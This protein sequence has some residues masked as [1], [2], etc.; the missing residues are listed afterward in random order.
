MKSTH[1]LLFC[2]VALLATSPLFA[3]NS[4][5][6]KLH[7]EKKANNLSDKDLDA[8]KDKVLKKV[9]LLTVYISNIA[10][11]KADDQLR[12]DNITQ[13]V[14]LFQDKNNTYVEVSSK[15]SNT[16]R[17]YSI[18]QYFRRLY[19]VDAG[20]V[21]ITFYEVAHLSDFRQ[22]PD[23]K[24]Y[25]TAHIYQLYEKYD[26]EGALVYTDRTVKKIDVTIDNLVKRVGDQEVSVWDVKLGNIKV[27]ETN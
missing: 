26:Y 3:Q 11:K 18:N 25:G 5:M 12:R 9:N 24:Y 22:A 6:N 16:V 7:V 2:I 4:A 15:T 8:F 1:T 10:N 20:Q 27:Q 19:A 13:A 23:G 21:K 14:N 17:K